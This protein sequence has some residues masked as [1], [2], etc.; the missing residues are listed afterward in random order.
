MYKVEAYLDEGNMPYLV[1][2]ECGY[3][4]NM[5]DKWNDVPLIYELCKKLRITE[6]ATEMV[7]LLVFDNAGHAIALRE[8]STGSNRNSIVDTAQIALTMLLCGG[9]ACVLVH[10]HPSGETE[11]STDDIAITKRVS[12]AL[13]LLNLTIWDHLIVGRHDYKSLAEM[14]LI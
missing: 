1:K 10:N 2:E 5:T 14:G 7:L 12:E 3:A 6:R 11:P 4:V 9:S 8:L 13:K